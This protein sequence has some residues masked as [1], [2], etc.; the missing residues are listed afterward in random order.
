[1]IEYVSVISVSVLL[2]FFLNPTGL[3]LSATLG[4][5]LAACA[6]I[7]CLRVGRL[8]NL[9]YRARFGTVVLALVAAFCA[10]GGVLSYGAATYVGSLLHDVSQTGQYQLSN[11]E[12]SGSKACQTMDSVL[13]YVNREFGT[14]VIFMCDSAT[15]FE[16]LRADFGPK[17]QEIQVGL[18]NRLYRI[19]IGTVTASL[20]MVGICLSISGWHASR[21]MSGHLPRVLDRETR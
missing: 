2:E 7:G 19:Q 10:F 21:G 17:L 4:V 11:I 12:W 9:G 18:E 20:L 15:P 1:M 8:F 14:N 5:I 6:L 16:Q 3:A 13:L